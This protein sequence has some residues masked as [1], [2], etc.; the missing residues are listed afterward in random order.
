MGLAKHSHARYNFPRILISIFSTPIVDN[1]PVY[2]YR[3]DHCGVEFDRKQKFAD[4]P[5]KNCPECNK[6]SLRKIYKPAVIVFK[7]SGFYATDHKSSLRKSG[8]TKSE[9]DSSDVIPSK[10]KSDSGE[11][12]TDKSKSAKNE[13]TGETSKSDSD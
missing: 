1:M 6:K 13:S 2:T 9:S 5:L 3:C 7:G 12:K 10:E 4:D 11:S 8:L